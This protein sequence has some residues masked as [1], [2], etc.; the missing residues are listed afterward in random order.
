MHRLTTLTLLFIED[1][2]AFAKNTIDFLQIYFG[3]V[4]HTTTLKEA[5]V[6]F[7]TEDPD[8]I[9]SD[10]KVED[11]NGLEFIQQVRRRNKEIPIIV[12]SAHK[13]EEFLFK[14][15]PLGILSYEVK[16]INYENFL[17]LLRKITEHFK[18][19]SSFHISPNL[20]YDYKNKQ[21]LLENKAITLTKKEMLF[22]ELL[23]KYPKQVVA[24]HMIQNDVW[25]NSI[26]S[27]SAIKNLI[28]RLRK[29]VGQDFVQTIHGVGY[30]LITK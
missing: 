13:E 17:A 11:G 22:I 24:N 25:E 27:D 9:L 23:L 3:K 26:M 20:V 21:L 5:L 14:A 30:K 28:F 19:I 18:E 7:E 12:M 6:L 2:E 15:I 10:I 29:K 1:N 4:L 16:P 8:L